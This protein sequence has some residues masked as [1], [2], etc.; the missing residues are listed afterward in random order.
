[1]SQNI[2]NRCKSCGKRVR[3]SRPDDKIVANVLEQPGEVSCNRCFTGSEWIRLEETPLNE[4]SDLF[5]SCRFGGKAN[6]AGHC[7]Y[8]SKSNECEAFREVFQ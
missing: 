4:L 1:M 3:I 2:Y 7:R 8:C 5:I 6:L